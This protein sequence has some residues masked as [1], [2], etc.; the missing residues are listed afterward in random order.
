[1]TVRTWAL[2]ALV[3]AGCSKKEAATEEPPEVKA[4]RVLGVELALPST[5]RPGGGPTGATEAS[6][7]R[8]AS[9]DAPVALI[10]LTTLDMDL[11]TA[12]DE[13]L[14]FL[15]KEISKSSAS[16]CQLRKD[17]DRTFG[18]C[19]GHA[20]ALASVVYVRP[21]ANRTVSMLFLSTQPSDQTTAEAD[22][23][24]GTLRVP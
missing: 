5:W 1:M 13:R 12:D 22:A 2:I 7:Y 4:T 10:T 21:D 18:R 3:S 9:A 8:G 16:D 15:T 17:G 11:A 14:L 20:G 6:F 24:F 19:V 23:I